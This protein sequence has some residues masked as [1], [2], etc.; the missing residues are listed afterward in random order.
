M[1]RLIIGAAGLAIAGFFG[2]I[3]LAILGMIAAIAIPNVEQSRHIAAVHA[4]PESEVIHQQVLGSAYAREPVGA[5]LVLFDVIKGTGLNPALTTLFVGTMFFV[6]ILG[7]FVILWRLT[8]RTAP[9]EDAD[10]QSV[11]ELHRQAQH[12]AQRMEALETILLE[13]SRPQP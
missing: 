2:L 5:N 9:A 3:A 10:S 11:Q 4:S 12:L 13:R 6:F 1:K 8:R 7:T